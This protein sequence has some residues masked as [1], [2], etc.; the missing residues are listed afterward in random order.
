MQE[1]DNV[2]DLRFNSERGQ[3]SALP[4]DSIKS[5]KVDTR[6]LNPKHVEDL[7]ESVAVLGLIEPLVVD[8]N[9]VLLAGGHRL[10][11]IKLLQQQDPEAFS[12]QFPDNEIP[13]RVIPIS[14]DAEPERALQIEVAENEHRRDYTPAEVR[15]IADN[16]LKD[17]Y[18]DA[19][20]RPPTGTKT[21]MPAL[22]TVI[23]KNI[24][25]I[26]RYLQQNQDEDK[27]TLTDVR[28]FLKRAQKSLRSWNKK[29]PA[30][31]ASK[32]LSERL[33]EILH[34]IDEAMANSEKKQG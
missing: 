26:H 27:K 22:S 4:L 11:A 5:R 3:R 34:L 33:P 28:V 20:G 31:P 15:K 19:T 14:A 16:L 7:Q 12:L 10:A 25:T 29:A 24:R 8:Q 13:V 2:A 32:A 9:A 18:S 30:D 6:P 1:R 23:G 21:L 17:V